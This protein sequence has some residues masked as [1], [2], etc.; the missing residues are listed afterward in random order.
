[1][2]ALGEGA[3][4]HERGTPVVFGPHTCLLSATTLLAKGNLQGCLAHEKA[5]PQR[6]LLWAYA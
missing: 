6:T 1:M 4:S 2:M 3:V 5:H